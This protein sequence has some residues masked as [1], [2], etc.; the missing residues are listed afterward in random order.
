MPTDAATGPAAVT[1][2]TTLAVTTGIARLRREDASPGESDDACGGVQQAEPDGPGCADR[3]VVALRRY[4]RKVE[5]VQH[6]AADLRHGGLTGSADRLVV[7]A[8]L[9]S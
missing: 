6:V 5:Q 8:R 2:A 7:C 1:P 9:P 3:V 4:L